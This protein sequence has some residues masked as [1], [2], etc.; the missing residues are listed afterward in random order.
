V[1]RRRRERRQQIALAGDESEPAQAQA[2]RLDAD[3]EAV[4]QP[5]GVG[6]LFEHRLAHEML[7]H[8]QLGGKLVGLAFAR[9]HGCVGGAAALGDG[10]LGMQQEMTD[11]VGDGE[12]PAARVGGAAQLYG[13]PLAER[14]ESRLGAEGLASAFDQ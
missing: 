5:A 1:P 8:E 11:L 9:R 12:A 10:V 4:G 14:H 3:V 7:R 6:A 13:V 2:H